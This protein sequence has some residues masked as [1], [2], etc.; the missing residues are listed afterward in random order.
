MA[1]YSILIPSLIDVDKKYLKV[2]VESLRESGFD[3]DIIVVGNGTRDMN[4][5]H[6]TPIKGI[7][8][9][10]VTKQ[11]GQCNAVNRAAEQVEGGIKWIMVSNSDMY[12]APGWDKYLPNFDD[13][14]PLCFS[15]NLI[16]P[17]NNPGSAKPFKKLDAGFTLE[18][19]NKPK[20]DYYVTNKNE[21]NGKRG[22]PGSKTQSG[23]NL[24][25]F[26]RLDVWRTIG[27]Y[28]E[29]YDPWGSNSDT[30][31]QTKI[32]LAGITP[33]RLLDVLVYHFSN[34]SGTFEGHQD[35]WQ[36]N[37]DYYQNKWGFNRDQLGSDVWMNKNM[38]PEDTKDSNY[39]PPWTG[40]YA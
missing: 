22:G 7:T 3:G 6:D 21:Y 27:G 28:D 26:I 25:F 10:N 30:D 9:F 12:Y 16:E 38:L 18:E 39:Q 15:P 17:T 40:K 23:F 2:C 34:K 14:T 32:N 31:L 11:Q 4:P 37:W 13:D 35:Y 5:L 20:V 33:V 36:K 8:K 1:K 29:H 19:F 24:P